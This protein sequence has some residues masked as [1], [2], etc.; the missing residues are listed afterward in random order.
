MKIELDFSSLFFRLLVYFL[1]EPGIL[2]ENGLTM[3]GDLSAIK[4][5]ALSGYFNFNYF[6]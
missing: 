5:V 3:F 6:N 4:F 1:Y 2:I